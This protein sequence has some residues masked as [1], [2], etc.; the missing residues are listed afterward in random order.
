MLN[1]CNFIGNLGSDPETRT[2]QNGKPVVN[3]SLGVT[4]KWKDGKRT[5]WIKIVIFNE[6]LA[7]IAQNYLKKGSKIFIQGAWQ[8]RKWT[9]QSGQDK[10]STELVLQ[11]YSGKIVMLDSRGEGGGE[12]DTA[13]SAQGVQKN[14]LPTSQQQAIDDMDDQLPDF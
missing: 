14:D 9:D 11:N 1:E 3:L 12:Y 10:Y 4:E 6:H 8:T 2:M 13:G 7:K 5:E